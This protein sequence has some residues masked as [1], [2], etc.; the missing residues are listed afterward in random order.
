MSVE[1][2]RAYLQVA[3]DSPELK[4]QLN[5]V[6]GTQEIVRLGR[7]YGY[8]FDVPELMEA[9]SSFAESPTDDGRPGRTRATSERPGRRGTATADPERS[10]MDTGRG[11][12][13]GPAPPSRMTPRGHHPVPG[14][15]AGGAH[16]RQAPSGP[17]RTGAAA[18]TDPPH[19][20]YRPSDRPG[21]AV[22]ADQL[23]QLKIKPP[24]ADLQH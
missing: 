5:A 13:A 4:Q 7:R 1:S 8:T 2:S 12:G 9:S 10:G 19:H 17:G 18:E 16:A 14:A 3:Y 22:V 21:L 24:S 23:P 20:E 11:H 15:P 6:T